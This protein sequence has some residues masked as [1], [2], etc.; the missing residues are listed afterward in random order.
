MPNNSSNT[1]EFYMSRC[2]ELALK[3]GKETKSNPMV[4]A[5]LVHE[6][7]II[8]EGWHEQFG[9]PHAE[10]NAINNVPKKDHHLI[11][12]ST[13]YVSLEPCCFHGKTPPCVDLI[14]SEGIKKVVIGTYDSDPR[15]HGKT[16]KILEEKG[17]DVSIGILQEECK[18]LIKKFEANLKKRPYIILKWAQ[19]FDGYMGCKSN[20]ILISSGISNIYSHKWRTEVDGILIGKSTAILDN[21]SLTSRLYEG[22]SPQRILLDSNLETPL[23]NH[24]FTDSYETFVFNKLRSGIDGKVQYILMEDL[25]DIEELL[26]K[27]VDLEIFSIIIEGG[28]KVLNSFIKSGLWDEARVIKSMKSIEKK[29]NK[30]DLVLAPSIN[31][32]LVKEIPVEDDTILFIQLK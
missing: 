26:S 31:G 14:I 11:K 10:V 27:L 2:I 30:D 1:K 28:S 9:G 21:P 5:V 20:R 7:M 3:G 4:G 23:T 6:D 17:I 16:I 22:D 29:F 24:L 13:M 18:N 32:K 15:M 12:N 19:T 8:G 25:S